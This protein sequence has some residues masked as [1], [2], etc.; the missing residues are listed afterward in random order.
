MKSIITIL[1]SLTVAVRAHAAMVRV[2]EVRDARTLVIERDGSRQ[3]IRL[4]GIAIVD[5][6][7]ALEL[8]RWT[9]GT[10]WVLV[11]RQPNGEHLVFRS[12]DALFINRELV[13]RGYAR[14]TLAGIEPLQQLNVT[15]LGQWNPPGPQVSGGPRS[16]ENDTSTGRRSSGSRAP[17]TRTPRGRSAGRA[18]GRAAEGERK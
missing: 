10:S 3:S 6:M 11:E 2:V 5:E 4:A 16:P 15:Y 12:P 17:K 14:A 9:V 13:L 8:L 1:L 7:R 18:A